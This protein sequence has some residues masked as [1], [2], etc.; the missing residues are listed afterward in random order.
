MAEAIIYAA[1]IVCFLLLYLAFKLDDLHDWQKI[2]KFTLIAFFFIFLT[3]V[4]KTVVDE[5]T[6]CYPV[7]NQTNDINST[8][9]DLLYG[10]HCVT[11]SEGTAS[12]FYKTML[13]FTRIMST[14]L[15]IYV[16]ILL[17]S[18]WNSLMDKTR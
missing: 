13:W 1:G 14:I 16:F 8:F 3:F 4:G 10:E 18:S 5:Q 15:L 17:F 2:L 7:V 11:E 6:V 12:T 9:T